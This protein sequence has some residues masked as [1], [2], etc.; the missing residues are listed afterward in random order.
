MRKIKNMKTITPDKI[1][2]LDENGFLNNFDD[3][4]PFESYEEMLSFGTRKLYLK[5]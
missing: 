5:K 4:S 3:D 2:E 1:R